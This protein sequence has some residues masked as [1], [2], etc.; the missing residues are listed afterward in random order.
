M[1]AVVTKINGLFICYVAEDGRE[2]IDDSTYDELMT[3]N[4]NDVIEL[5]DER[6]Q[7]LE[8]VIS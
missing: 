7:A 4:K 3:V 1:K 2:G 5:T 6:I 8:T